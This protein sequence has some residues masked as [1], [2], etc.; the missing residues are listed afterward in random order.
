MP[1]CPVLPCPSHAS[2][3]PLDSSLAKVVAEATLLIASTD[4]EVPNCT[5][6]LKVRKQEKKTD[7]SARAGGLHRKQTVERKQARP[8]T[9]HKANA[10][11]ETDV[12]RH[13]VDITNNS[14]TEPLSRRHVL[15]DRA[16]VPCG[17]AHCIDCGMRTDDIH[18]LSTVGTMYLRRFWLRDG[19]SHD[20]ILAS[21]RY[22]A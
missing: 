21:L 15:E 1:H 13:V 6:Q 10:T 7:P 16:A 4:I 14:S 18:K 9:Y 19:R 8:K 3:A 2:I 22:P 20:S 11:N 5:R 17:Q 12:V